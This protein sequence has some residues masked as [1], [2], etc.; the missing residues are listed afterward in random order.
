MT[1]R[2]LL[3]KNERMKMKKIIIPKEIVT[4]NDHNEVARDK[5]V[6]IEEG[7]ITRFIPKED[8]KNYSGEFEVFDFSELT[9]LPGFVQTHVHLCQ[10]LFR[11]LADDL[12]L[13]D[14][15]QKKIFP[16]EHQHNAESLRYS[17]ALGIHEL[18]T[19]GTTTIL[20][21]GT[22][23]HHRSVFEELIKADMRAVSG[24]CMT[25]MNDLYPDFK[26][27]T[28]KSLQT[29]YELAEEFHGANG[30]K[31][32]YGFA[33]RFVLSCTEELMIEAFQMTKDFDGAFYHT[34]SS[35]NKGEIEIVK[36]MTGKENI[37]YFDSI[38]VLG[39]NTVLAH[40]IHTNEREVE[41]LK[42]R[43]VR[44]AHCPSTNLKLGSGIANIPRYIEE[45]IY[46]SIGAD[47]PPCNNNL[48]MFEEMRAAALIQKPIHGPTSMNAL[49]VLRLATIEGAKALHLENEI[50][51][52]EIGKKADLI[53]LDLSGSDKSLLDNDKNIFSDI[54]YASNKNDVKDVMIEGKWVVRNGKSTVY[55]EREI[56]SR[57]KEELTKLLARTE[58]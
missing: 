36:K 54:V 30:G 43:K 47:G 58:V 53:L 55:D 57:G 44:V 38:G 19:G 9:L 48:S 6:V 1:T 21:M 11:G 46:V 45:G 39:E 7:I 31:I 17:A 4:V 35:E 16:F 5:A 52:V 23:N 18:Q 25:D 27:E 28:K 40:S 12:E 20:D 33:P 14:W 49:T 22:I 24:K 26:E 41:I 51:S 50:G 56:V 8:A 34:H 13:L 37:E 3:N 2:S 10:T 32:R 42:E 29:S 15:L